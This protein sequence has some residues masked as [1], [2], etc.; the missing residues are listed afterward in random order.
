MT[1]LERYREQLAG[2]KFHPDTQQEQVVQDLQHI[3]DAVLMA[4]KQ[5]KKFWQ[6]SLNKLKLSKPRVVKGLYLWGPVGVG[7]TSLLDLLYD[8]LPLQKK[9]RLHFHHFM[10]HVHQEL[11]RLEGHTNPLEL[12]ALRFVKHAKIIC[13]D[14]FLVTDIADAML[15]ANFLK[16]LF[17]QGVTLV[18]TA[19]T[20]PDELYRHGL[21]RARFLPA[22]ELLKKYL[23]VI[24]LDTK[25]DYRLRRQKP[26]SNY[27]CPLDNFAERSMQESFVYYEQKKN[28]AEQDPISQPL[29]HSLK[30]CSEVKN[31]LEITGRFIPVVRRS[32]QVI[33]F[34]FHDICAS[35]RSQL[36]YLEIARHFSTVL[37]SQVPQFLE[38]ER[39]A[40]SYFIKLV[41]V[42]YDARVHLILSAAVPVKDLYPRGDLA[43]EFKRTKS[44][45]IEMQGEEYL[46][47]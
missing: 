33:W 37:I 26:A 18:T 25:Q 10:Q 41:D 11:K 1:P 16:A 31:G 12:V 47:Y 44:R 43:E 35:P 8:S 6:H 21:Q 42:F 29:D 36:D 24:H 28:F 14:E 39:N 34:D 32:Q 3:Y 22:I 19:N 40:V 46:R 30:Q 45:L 7:K 2:G 13:L 17:A 5:R 27:F 9:I 15:L 38:K 23:K 4:E 20:Q